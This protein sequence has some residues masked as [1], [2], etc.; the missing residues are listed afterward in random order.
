VSSTSLSFSELGPRPAEPARG[1]LVNSFLS[2]L[3]RG[4]LRNPAAA[5]GALMLLIV[6]GAA[7]AAPIIAPHDPSAQETGHRLAP[8][9]WDPDGLATYPLGTD[10]VGRDLLSR[11]LFG[12]RVSL[13]LGLSCTV[14]A[15]LIGIALGLLAGLGPPRL[16]EVIMGVADVQIAFPFL[17]LAIALI[18]VV[19][20]S[21]GSLVAILSVFGWVQFARLVRGDVLAERERDYVLAARTLGA[22]ELRVAVRHILPNVLSPVMVIWTFTLAQIILIE[23]AL[24]FLGLGVQ[25]PTPSWGSMLADGRNYIDTA[26]WL[27]TFPGLAIMLTVL[28]VNL[29]G[30][31]LRDALDP[32]A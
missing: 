16:G 24:S 19:G 30:D 10:Q 18:S 6:L 27:G 28:A 9:A 26:W 21:F 22:V 3:R 20:P 23:S 31:A 7:V 17:V 32:H 13:A 12:A 5:I 14:V 4:L 15:S 1:P 29:V 25:P 2:R 8:P 11:A